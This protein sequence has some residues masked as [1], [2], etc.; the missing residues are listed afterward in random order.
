M[1]TNAGTRVASPLFGAEVIAAR[2]SVSEA[3]K[4]L[5]FAEPRFRTL[6]L[7][8]DASSGILWKFIAKHAPVYFSHELLNDL[9]GVQNALVNGDDLGLRDY[10]PDDVR[11]LVLGSHLP[12]AFSLGGDLR[13]FRELILRGDRHGLAA[14]ARKA[15][16]AVYNHATS[17]GQPY[18]TISLVQGAAMGGGF[19][20]ALAGQVVIAERGVRFGLPEVLFGLFPGMGAYTLLR[21]RVPA[22]TAERMILTAG[23][24]SAEELYELGIIDELAYPGEGE[25]AV[26]DYVR[27]QR[28]SPGQYGFRKALLRVNAIDHNE[29][30]GIADEWVETALHLSAKNLRYID[31]LIKS[32]ERLGRA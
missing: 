11:Y 13:L 19:E 23:T 32:Q 27:R 30:Y 10:R 18:T 17:A 12:D 1:S 5:P 16:D 21:Q 29:L 4:P 20:A 31:R 26:M 9:R 7:R 2:V 3:L 22:K 24:Y 6:D 8:Y 15:M 25:Q 28:M 14:Y